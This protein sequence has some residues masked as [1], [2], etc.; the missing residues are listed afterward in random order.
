MA[1]GWLTFNSHNQ[2]ETCGDVD[3]T[4]PR[5]RF[6]PKDGIDVP[7][8]DFHA[9]RAALAGREEEHLSK[10][11]NVTDPK[12]HTSRSGN[13]RTPRFG[14]TFATTVMVR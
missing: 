10:G 1:L 6:P 8:H 14:G 5:G 4:A 12:S 13:Y 11:T 3:S 7:G 9:G 2:M